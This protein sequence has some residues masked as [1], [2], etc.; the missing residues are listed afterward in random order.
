MMTY[1]KSGKAFVELR[2]ET[3]KDTYKQMEDEFSSILKSL[4]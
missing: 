3:T 4:K 1:F 2:L